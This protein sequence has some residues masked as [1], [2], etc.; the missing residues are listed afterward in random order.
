[1]LQIIE[2]N[3][4]EMT[5]PMFVTHLIAK[6]NFYIGL[7]KIEECK[8]VLGEL[9][10]LKKFAFGANYRFMNTLLKH[11]SSNTPI[12]AYEKDFSEYP[13]LLHQIMVIRYLEE[14]NLELAQFYWAKLKENYPQLFGDD[15]K[16]NG[17]K[18]LF[19]LCLSKQSKQEM[20]FNLVKNIDEKNKEK[21]ILNILKD[22]PQ[23]IPKKQLY[24]ML[25]GGDV[26]DKTEIS[27]MQRMISRLRS[28][29]HNI[30]FRKGCYFF[31][32]QSK[33]AS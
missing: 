14:N 30:V 26:V 5:D 22:A 15:F 18:C 16:Y 2:K 12:Y 23:P 10:K 31:E 29:G 1:M 13:I 11:L 27:K 6:F 7:E 25:W 33:K 32:A 4:S 9:K 20:D 17:N 21:S 28:R 24:R 19:S 3:E 8:M